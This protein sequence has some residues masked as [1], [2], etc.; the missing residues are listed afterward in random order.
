MKFLHFCIK[1]LDFFI[2]LLKLLNFFTFSEQDSHCHTKTPF[3]HFNESWNLA[4][5][6][7]SHRLPVF[8]NLS[9]FMLG[10]SHPKPA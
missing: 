5:E 6:Q 10:I 3:S 4:L 9:S 8:K 7:D 1:P 2:H